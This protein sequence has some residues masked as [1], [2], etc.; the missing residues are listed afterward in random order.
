MFPGSC[1]HKSFSQQPASRFHCMSHCCCI[2]SRSCCVLAFTQCIEMPQQS[3]TKSGIYRLNRTWMDLEVFQTS[4]N[5]RKLGVCAVF[6]IDW[7][8]RQHAVTTFRLVP[9]SRPTLWPSLCSAPPTLAL[10]L[11]QAL[12]GTWCTSYQWVKAKST[13]NHGFYPP[14]FAGSCILNQIRCLESCLYESP[15][16]IVHF[17]RVYKSGCK[18]ATATVTGLVWFFYL[19]PS[20]VWVSFPS[21]Q[22]SV[23]SSPAALCLPAGLA[24]AKNVSCQLLPIIH[25]HL[26]PSM[27]IKLPFRYSLFMY[28]V[29]VFTH[30][31][32]SVV[33]S[34]TSL[35]GPSSTPSPVP[36]HHAKRQRS[37]AFAT[38]WWRWWCPWNKKISKRGYL[39]P[40][41]GTTAMLPN[42]MKTTHGITCYTVYLSLA[43][44]VE[45]RVT[46]DCLCCT[47]PSPLPMFVSNSEDT[48]A[49]WQT[50][51]ESRPFRVSRA[52][53]GSKPI[54]YKM[55]VY[56]YIYTY[57]CICMYMYVYIYIHYKLEIHIIIKCVY[58]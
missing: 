57:V 14:N 41:L 51:S 58:I 47:C 42:T 50:R 17:R 3:C 39:Y 31:N 27:F 43:L 34:A 19:Q 6:R 37:F 25:I 21:Q 16:L 13:R 28:G 29:L 9:F 33:H 55:Y 12:L 15:Y 2:T 40:I 54:M 26:Y 5:N 45:N 11:G 38:C 35:L 1:E 20:Y 18:S 53:H 10:Q 4:S 56:I 52:C 46:D 30:R 7:K 32:L 24:M 36:Q 22:S 8:L 44:L 23:H 48:T 49:A